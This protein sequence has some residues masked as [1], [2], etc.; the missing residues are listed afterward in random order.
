MTLGRV[1]VLFLGGTA[2][3]GS[4]LAQERE[5]KP[6]AGEPAVEMAKPAPAMEKRKW[7]VGKWSVSETHEKNDWSPGGTGKGTSVIALG[8]GGYSQIITYTS[9]G[10]AGKFSGHGIIAWDPEVKIYRSAW[11]DSATPGIV[12]TDCREEGRD[13]VCSGESMMQG[14]KVAVRSRSIAPNPA[15]WTEVTEM[16]TNGGPFTKVRTLEFKRT[17]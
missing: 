16:S 15:G 11:A 1:L 7:V 10:P 3:G 6:A 14:K 9:T 17:Q 8:P 12:T 4:M 2:L 5:R 13:W